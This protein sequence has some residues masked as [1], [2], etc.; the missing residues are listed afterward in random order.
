MEPVKRHLIMFLLDIS[1]L[2]W[3]IL[4]FARKDAATELSLPTPCSMQ[5]HRFMVR[6]GKPEKNPDETK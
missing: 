4:S 1:P 5:S 2:L 3:H 6:Q